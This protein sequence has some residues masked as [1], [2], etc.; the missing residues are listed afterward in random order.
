MQSFFN[1]YLKQSAYE[2]DQLISQFR[3]VKPAVLM[4][5]FNVN[6]RDTPAGSGHDQ[7]LSLI[8]V[9]NTDVS[10]VCSFCPST[11]NVYNVNETSSEKVYDF[12]FGNGFQIFNTERVFTP[13]R[14][15]WTI[16]HNGRDVPLSSHFG[17]TGEFKN[18]TSGCTIQLKSCDVKEVY[19]SV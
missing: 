9:F 10:Q 16:Q 14:E 18:F 15:N 5:D 1:T 8:S 12:V 17:I 13:N 11:E 7:F 3:D 2:I 19:Q 4:G 6:G